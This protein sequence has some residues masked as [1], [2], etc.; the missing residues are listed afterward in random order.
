MH[1]G[2]ASQR[3][4]AGARV[5]GMTCCDRFLPC[6]AS[7]RSSR[8]RSS[9]ST[10]RSPPRCSA[11]SR[12]CTRSRSARAAPLPSRPRPASTSLVPHGL[13]ALERADTVIVPGIGD[14]AW[15]LAGAAGGAARGRGARR[16]DRVDLHRR[17]R[18]RRGRPA[19]RPPR[20]DALA[21]RRAARAARSPRSD[22]EPDVLYVDDGAVLTSA[23]VAAG[24]DL[25]LHIVR[26]DHGAQSPTRRAADRRR[27]PPRRRSG[28]VRRA[29]AARRRRRRRAG[30]DARLDGGAPRAAADGR[31]DGAPRRLQ[32][33]FVRAPLRRRDR[34]DAAAVADRAPRR[35]GPAPAGGD[36]PAGRD[37]RRAGRLRHGRRP[38]PAL[39]ARRRDGADRVPAG[40]PRRRAYDG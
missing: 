17:V 25:C 1:A 20:R 2:A 29:P 16:A 34:H 13:D 30:A 40:V 5:A 23:G 38:A 26:A 7:S 39:R 11:A 36:R 10:S 28:A 19:R 9:R 3:G 33:A 37:R 6:I 4:R 18:A 14:D 27:R 12:R 31:A 35:R 15:P 22:V 24:I 8:A 32:R 21:L